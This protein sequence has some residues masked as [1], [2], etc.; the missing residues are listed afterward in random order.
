M[1]IS[2]T[3]VVLVLVVGL[4]LASEDVSHLWAHHVGTFEVV[5]CQEGDDALIEEL[6]M[7]SRPGTRNR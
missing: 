1:R 5:Q 2:K 3:G 6:Q 4:G 7:D